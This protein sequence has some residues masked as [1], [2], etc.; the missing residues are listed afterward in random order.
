MFTFGSPDYL[1][2]VW[3]PVIMLVWMQAPARPD[4]QE[5]APFG[6]HVGSKS[7]VQL[8]PDALRL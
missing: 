4:C 6:R 3:K 8:G 5:T 2:Q 1:I 7:A